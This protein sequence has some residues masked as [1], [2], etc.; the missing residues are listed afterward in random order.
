ML[1]IL[2]ASHPGITRMNAIARSSLWWPG[3]DMEIEN[4]A[5]HCDACQANQRNP[6]KAPLHPWVWPKRPWARL[7]IDFAGPFLNKMFLVTVDAMS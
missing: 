4:K 2:Q 5:K 1:D 6:A 3:L 7:H